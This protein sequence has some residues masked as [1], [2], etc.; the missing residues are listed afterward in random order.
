[1]ISKII[2]DG[3]DFPVGKPDANQYKKDNPFLDVSYKGLPHLGEDWNGKG[4]GSTDLGDLIYAIS[5][6]VVTYAMNAGRGWGNI[7]IIVHNLPDGTQV[8]SLYAHLQT[9]HVNIDD[10]VARGSEIGTMGDGDGYYSGFA[11][12]HFEIRNSSCQLWNQPGSGY[13]A[14]YSGWECPSDFINANRELHQLYAEFVTQDP[15]PILP[16]GGQ[17]TYWSIQFRNHSNVDWESH[18]DNN[19][20]M[21]LALGLYNRAATKVSHGLA[22]D[23]HKDDRLAKLDEPLV[24]PG[25]IGTFTFGLQASSNNLEGD[26]IIKFT[27][28]NPTG[29]FKDENGVEHCCFIT[30]KIIHSQAAD[31]SANNANSGNLISNDDASLIR[32]NQNI[33]AYQNNTSTNKQISQPTQ[34]CPDESDDG[35]LVVFDEEKNGNRH[36]NAKNNLLEIVQTGLEDPVKIHYSAE[37]PPAQLI[38]LLD[39]ANHTTLSA[40]S[41]AGGNLYTLTAQYQPQTPIYGLYDI[42]LFGRLFTYKLKPTE[43]KVKGLPNSLTIKA[44]N[45]DQWK[46]SIRLPKMPQMKLGARLSNTKTKAGQPKESL[47]KEVTTDKLNFKLSSTKTSWQET[48]TES[49]TET[50]GVYTRSLKS[51]EMYQV[52]GWKK[53]QKKTQNRFSSPINISLNGELVKI[54]GVQLVSGIV[55]LVRNF[56]KAVKA[57]KDTVPKVGWYIDFN[58]QILQGSFDIAWGWREDQSYQAYYYLGA[59]AKINLFEVKF[60]VGFGIEYRSVVA[61]VCV[62]FTGSAALSFGIETIGPTKESMNLGTLKGVIGAGG[63][64]R[65]GAGKIVKIE[66]GI[67]SSITY[68][69]KVNL[70]L[71]QGL[72]IAGKKQ[73]DGIEVKLSCAVWGISKVWTTKL[74]EKQT[75]GTFNFPG[76]PKKAR[77]KEFSI[78]E[79]SNVIEDSITQG[80]NLRVFEKSVST[81][82]ILFGMITYED[83]DWEQLS[84]KKVADIIAKRIWDDSDDLELDKKTVNGLAHSIRKDC[85]LLAAQSYSRDWMSLTDLKKY[86]SGNKMTVIINDAKDPAK[87]FESTLKQNN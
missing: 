16:I 51:G 47:A 65:V 21:V 23:W 4:G 22:C 28:K 9:I 38:V 27:P 29:Y 11:H 46:L 64:V 53:P 81:K 70:H 50:Y 20:L 62:N 18:N 72:A 43:Y 35:I 6:G 36:F 79:I 80:L 10:E 39:G 55:D 1:M 52:E 31:N 8:Q 24:Q 32:Q 13:S 60:E 19:Q 57:F 34:P 45:P 17:A 37:N 76:K 77:Q 42:D 5:N 40:E 2:S 59:A 30:A 44:Y 25:E 61:Q 75:L 71:K 7:I 49:L 54:D 66:G 12:L 68:E 87:S 73:W 84:H 78:L 15:M 74:M 85:D 14:Q 69:G 3:F 41:R 83:E 67:K 63:Y 26:Y 82:D 33:H 48:T 56:T 86:L 58:C